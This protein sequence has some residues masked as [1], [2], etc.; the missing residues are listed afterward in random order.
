MQVLESLLGGVLVCLV[1]VQA[2]CWSALCV[3]LLGYTVLCAGSNLSGWPM[4]LVLCFMMISGGFLV[5][6]GC[7]C[8]I[9]PTI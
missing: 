7:A 1:A 8:T 2:S 4:I 3:Q 9:V 5:S 6:T